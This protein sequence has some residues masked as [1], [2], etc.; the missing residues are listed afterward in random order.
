MKEPHL[1]TGAWGKGG[2]DTVRNIGV[3]GKSAQRR[4]T[5]T[6]TDA[7]RIAGVPIRAPRPSLVQRK[8]GGGV[9]PLIT[10]SGEHSPPRGKFRAALVSSM[11]K[12]VIFS[13][14]AG[15]QHS[16]SGRGTCTSPPAPVAEMAEKRS[17]LQVGGGLCW[18]TCCF[19]PFRFERLKFLNISAERVFQIKAHNWSN[20]GSIFAPAVR[21]AGA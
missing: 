9:R 10:S 5:V 11:K 4:T 2:S 7:A 18:Y 17:P 20:Q 21:N 6:R 8:V 12:I 13:T 15:Q 19:A 1:H 3:G 16:Y 14:L